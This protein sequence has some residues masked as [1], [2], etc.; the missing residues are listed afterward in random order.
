MHG[1]RI[2]NCLKQ[3]V[4][5]RLMTMDPD[6]QFIAAR[7]KEE[8][9]APDGIKST[10]T[11]MILWADDLNEKNYRG[12]IIIKGYNSMTLDYYWRV[13]NELY[14]GPY[15]YG[16]KSSDT[17]TYKFASKGKGFKHYSEYFEKLWDDTDLS[18]V[19]TKI[20][21]NPKSKKKK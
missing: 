21:S 12:K 9:A 16:Y 7:E 6:G 18:V 3:G 14:V 11:D 5:I 17:I 10:I 13:D 19:L 15:W 8:D 20:D 2:E 1:K 4:Q